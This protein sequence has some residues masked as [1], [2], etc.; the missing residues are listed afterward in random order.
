[1]ET[2]YESR[3]R[4][5]EPTGPMRGAQRWSGCAPRSPVVGAL[6]LVRGE[7]LEIG[8]RIGRTHR[9]S[10]ILRDHRARF[11]PKGVMEG[12]PVSTNYPYGTSVTTWGWIHLI[13]GAGELLLHPLLSVLGTDDHHARHL[14]HLG[15]GGPRQSAGARRHGLPRSSHPVRGQNIRCRPAMRNQMTLPILDPAPAS[16]RRTT[17]RPTATTQPPQLRVSTPSRR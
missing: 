11:H 9:L 7:F 15:A 8:D 17:V 6:V 13:V 14:C 3:G 2:G 1:M 5:N 4:V 10:E 12:S 16:A